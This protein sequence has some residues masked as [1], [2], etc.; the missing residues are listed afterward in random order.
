MS[1]NPANKHCLL[2][3]W[4]KHSAS[5]EHLLSKLPTPTAVPVPELQPS[6]SFRNLNDS[7]QRLKNEMNQLESHPPQQR[8]SHS[9][10]FHLNVKRPSDL[11]PKGP[12]PGIQRRMSRSFMAGETREPSDDKNVE[13]GRDAMHMM[14]EQEMPGLVNKLK[15]IIQ[16]EFKAFRRE[17]Q[18][19]REGV[20]SELSRQRE[21]L[22]QM[23]G[24]DRAAAPSKMSAQTANA[25]AEI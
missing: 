14:R 22:K 16:D 19:W 2:G 23:Q 8:E 5:T 13:V 12:T 1:T 6:S 15:D 3:N 21:T 4:R 25:L 20:E 24:G 9:Q 11:P 10:S 17:Q 18:Q 7:L